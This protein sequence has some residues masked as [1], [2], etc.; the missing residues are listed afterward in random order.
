MSHLSLALVMM[1]SMGDQAGTNTS[2]YP[3]QP[4]PFTQ[5]RLD[6]G[7]WKP[8]LETNS[9]TTVWYDFQKCEETGR[10]DNFA[11]AGGLKEGDFEGIY[12]NDSDVFKVIEGAA[13]T[14]ALAPNP[15]LDAY[16]DDLIAKIA[17]AQEDDGY[18]YSIRT[19]RGTD[20]RSEAAGPERWSNLR[21]SHELYNI[22]HMY[23]AAVA[24]HLATGKRSLLDVA[25]R[26]ADL[27]DRV[28][29]PGPDQRKDPPGHQEI[30]LGL[31][32]LYRLT[33]E[34]RYL[35]LAKF[36]LEQ[37]GRADGHKLYGPYSQDH[38]PVTEQAEAVGHAVRAGYM[39][40]AMTDIAALTGDPAYI[41]AVDRLWEDI[42]TK[43][44]YITGGI[45]ARRSGEAF[46]EPYELPNASAYNETCAA[47]ANAMWNHR[48]FLLHGD[49]KYIDVLER[50][51][52]N[53]FLAGVSFSGD[54]F[55][56]PNPL[57]FDGKT[58]FNQGEAGRAPWFACSC[59]PVNVLRFIP[60]IPGFVYA[61]RDDAIYVNLYIGGTANIKL[62]EQ[63]VRLTQKTDYPWS[64]EV[65]I[66][67]EPEQAGTCE[68]RLRI[69]GWATE[70]PIPGTLYEYVEP[71]PQKVKIEVNDQPVDFTMKQGFAAVTREW[72][73]GD[74]ITF[75]LP[76]S[77]RRVIAHERVQADA[78]RV[79]LERGPIVYCIEGV[80]HNGE[81]ADLVLPD[82]ADL[83]ADSALELLNGVM[84]LR[85]TSQ[86]VTLEPDGS[87]RL[88]TVQLQAV[89]YYA[90]A[91]R[92]IGPMTV[93]IPRTPQEARPAPLPT[94]AYTSR[95]S[96]S[97]VYRADSLDAVNDQREPARSDDG[98]IP[99]MTWWDHRGSDE[100]IQYDF[101]KAA[102]VSEVSVY[103]FDDSGHGACRPPASWRLLY[104][105]GDAWKPVAQP[106]AYGVEQD[107]YN[108]T[109]FE[110]VKTDALRLEVKLQPK[111]SA[112]ILEWQ[113]K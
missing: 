97:H 41:A 6:D 24:H 70:Q 45:G 74:A 30:E 51:L 7:F 1:M 27:A 42:V 67:V 82:D 59:C 58:K 5:V 4:V 17:A 14:L 47:I 48:L 83:T 68:L 87:R 44:L 39:Y 26:S 89:P 95:V 76:M 103:W 77:V 2:D 38:L 3:I 50:V 99:R 85:G 43:R 69:P 52:Y 84:V 102:E 60:S 22:G 61:V 66:H 25:L 40:S 9:E 19:I 53:G 81:V 8:R 80:D 90:W 16:L 62:G 29:G 94:L 96:A 101:P 88:E 72:Q 57:E 100:W 46:G 63:T 54:R 20:T 108:T 11:I 34:P 75:G 110:P 18:L 15:K 71:A 12:Y 91:H 78:G 28:F 56:Y 33:H 55:F 104:R 93:W 98:S 79:A 105:D 112:G 32:K 37:R 23:E 111:F 92:E 107:C 65:R 31:V 113:V 49:A 106:S 35:R 86:R 13:Y 21:A 109:R 64:G 36:F 73:A 10:I